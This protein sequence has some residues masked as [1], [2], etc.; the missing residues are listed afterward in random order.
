MI[1]HGCTVQLQTVDTLDI[2]CTA[3]TA[4]LTL[5]CTL[6]FTLVNC[7]TMLCIIFFTYYTISICNAYFYKRHFQ[8]ILSDI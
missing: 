3:N 5:H 2:Y 7:T 8:T 6:Q 1:V 4:Q